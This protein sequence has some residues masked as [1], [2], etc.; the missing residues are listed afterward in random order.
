MKT[1]RPDIS[2]P[3]RRRD[4]VAILPYV[5]RGCRTQKCVDGSFIAAEVELDRRAAAAGMQ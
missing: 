5:N 4:L 2:S 3:L 1:N